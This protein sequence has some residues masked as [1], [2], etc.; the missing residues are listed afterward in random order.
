MTDRGI[1]RLVDI[2]VYAPIGL[3]VEISRCLARLVGSGRQ[4]AE[5]QVVAARMIGAMVVKAGSQEVRHRLDAPSSGGES[6]PVAP[7]PGVAESVPA[8]DS[9]SRLTGADELPI[10]DYQS[11]A[12]SQVVAKLSSLDGEELAAVERFERTHRR[13]RTVLGKIE[14]LQ[15]V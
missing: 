1:D 2:S 13:R 8:T 6:S 9:G 10:V 12:A 14:Q 4:R 3:A 5:R 7:A 15:R 11:L